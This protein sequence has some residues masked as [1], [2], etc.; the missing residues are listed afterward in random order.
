[1]ILGSTW[2]GTASVCKT[3]GKLVIQIDPGSCYLFVAEPVTV[4]A[5]CTITEASATKLAF[6]TRTPETDWLAGPDTRHDRVG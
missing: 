5:L 2:T 3:I 1:M 6:Y 4:N